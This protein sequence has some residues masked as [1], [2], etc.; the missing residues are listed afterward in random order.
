MIGKNKM[1]LNDETIK[2][3]MQLYLNERIFRHGQRVTVVEKVTKQYGAVEWEI[4]I[5]ANEL[6]DPPTEAN[7]TPMA[8]LPPEQ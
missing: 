1:T 8:A 7:S 3:A 6:V 2:H 5:E 4:T